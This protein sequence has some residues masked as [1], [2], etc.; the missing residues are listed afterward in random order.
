MNTDEFFVGIKGWFVGHSLEL[1]IS[2]VILVIYFISRGIILRLITRHAQK[3]KLDESRMLYVK[4]I[5]GLINLIVFIALFG[6][7]WQI[8]LSGLSFYFA[9]IF[10]VVG[11][12]L[13]ANWSILLHRQNNHSRG[14][15]CNAHPGRL[16]R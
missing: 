10:T 12:A 5:T 14:P 4:K 2:L 11:V 6:L 1:F 7:I 15:C 3:N 9:S 16:L 13:F 8:S